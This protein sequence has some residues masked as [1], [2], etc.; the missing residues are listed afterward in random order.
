MSIEADDYVDKQRIGR[1][2]RW[3]RL[4]GLGGLFLA[5]S[6]FL[7]A[8]DGCNSPIVPAQY[9]WEAFC[10]PSGSVTEW[11][12]L[13]SV[14][15]AAYLLGLLALILGLYRFVPRKRAERTIGVASAVVFAVVIITYLATLEEELR[16]WNWAVGVRVGLGL[17][18]LVYWLRCVRMGQAG[19]MSMRWY[20][21]VLCLIWFSHFLVTGTT[22]Y[23]L[24]LS[25]LGS[26]LMMIGTTGEAKARS[27]LP[28]GRTIGH[29]LFARRWL[30]DVDD[31]GCRSCGYL[32]IGLTVPRCPEC[33][34][35]FA[36][37]DYPSELQLAATPGR[38]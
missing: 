15:I 32:L 6:F 37:S 21:S 26:T 23:G 19:L 7:P 30:I 16:R 33:G 13:F 11:V 28:L 12:W 29:L 8:V 25:I 22:Y 3:R 10:E 14:M 27:R 24:W 2:L 38:G 36:W 35:E 31:A 5:A 1:V 9:V 20:G 17:F 4:S 34:Q 18:S